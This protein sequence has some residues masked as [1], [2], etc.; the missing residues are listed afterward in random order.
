VIIIPY[1]LGFNYGKAMDFLSI[2]SNSFFCKD[3][4]VFEWRSNI[5]FNAFLIAILEI[6]NAS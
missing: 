6:A 2:S 3:S 5:N 1:C 4:S